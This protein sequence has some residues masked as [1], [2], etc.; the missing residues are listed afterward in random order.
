MGQWTAQGHAAVSGKDWASGLLFL[1]WRK[2]HH[3]LPPTEAELRKRHR[4]AHSCV[5]LPIRCIESLYTIVGGVGRGSR[6]QGRG[7]VSK[8][9]QGQVKGADGQRRGLG[10]RPGEC[11]A[12]NTVFK[13]VLSGRLQRLEHLKVK[14][15][16][17]NL[18][19]VGGGEEDTNIERQ[20]ELREFRK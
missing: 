19:G 12:G 8:E 4:R 16:K 3:Q 10:E 1:S 6:L 20:A 2:D 15:K 5:N 14:E 17:D 11:K 9:P 7:N 18:G 13:L